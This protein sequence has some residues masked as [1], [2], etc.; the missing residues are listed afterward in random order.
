MRYQKCYTLSY[1]LLI[2]VTLFA[3]EKYGVTLKYVFVPLALML[4]FGIAGKGIALRLKI[5]SHVLICLS[6]MLVMIYST[7]HSDVIGWSPNARSFCILIMS[8]ALL[9][10]IVPDDHYIEK[11]KRLYIYL[12]LFCALW[13]I[14]QSFGGIDR[15]NFQFVTGKKDVNYLAAFMLPGVY[16]AMR[17]VFLEKRDGNKAYILCV[18][19]SIMAL[20][21]LQSRASF[22]TL[23][24]VSFLCFCEYALKNKLTRDKMVGGIICVAVVAAAI[25]LLWNTSAFTRL[26]NT[27]S[28]EDDVRLEIWDHAIEAFYRNPVIGSGLGASNFIARTGVRADTHNNYIDILGDSGIIGMCLFL[29]LSWGLLKVPKGERLHMLTFFIACMLPLGFINGLQTISFWLPVLL[30]A[31]ECTI[32]KRRAKNDRH[33]HLTS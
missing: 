5:K 26:T 17:F 12:V 22:V 29:L 8:V 18:L 7:L 3:P 28:Y 10:E 19:V 24:I 30:L 11:I 1:A 31:H 16:M 9:Y 4:L 14:L 13:I 6:W 33:D 23:I 32:I 15:K 27:Q 20:L 25:A 2:A 21:L